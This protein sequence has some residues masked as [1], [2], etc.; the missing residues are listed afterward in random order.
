MTESQPES[1][2]VQ[3]ILT[4]ASKVNLTFQ[5]NAVPVLRELV[6]ENSSDRD[7]A[8][9]ELVLTA[10]P[11]FVRPRKWVIDQLVAG[12]R[13]HITDV[14]ID[15]SPSFLANLREAAKGE[16]RLTLGD[17]SGV[18]TE[19]RMPVEILARDEWGGAEE[20]PEIIAAFVT[21]N[22]PSVATILRQASKVLR[23][24]GL[25]GSFDGYQSNNP[26][27]VA[28]TLAGI[29]AALSRLELSYAVPPASFETEGQ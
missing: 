12:S 9:L 1:S 20:L 10:E 28:E 27:R 5:Q 6:L 7:L 2:D 14:N 19:K 4:A 15:L 29:W 13:F 16:L 8:D 21:P 23:E 24:N 26:R 18:L 11:S 3:L 17:P 25:D 22:D